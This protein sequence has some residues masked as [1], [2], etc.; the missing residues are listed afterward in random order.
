MR[1][2]AGTRKVRLSD[3]R[4]DV[5]VSSTEWLHM[6]I[7]YSGRVGV[8]RR[9]KAGVYLQS[10]IQRSLTILLLLDKVC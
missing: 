4:I 2:N 3:D 6:L 10:I 7:I 8:Q 5:G 1:G 9:L